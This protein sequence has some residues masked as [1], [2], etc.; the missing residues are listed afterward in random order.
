MYTKNFEMYNHTVFGIHIDCKQALMTLKIVYMLIVLVF[1]KEGRKDM[2]DFQNIPS[3][4]VHSF[5]DSIYLCIF[6]NKY[7]DLREKTCLKIMCTN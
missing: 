2:F 3:D 5:V 4:D 7:M 6:S 1:L